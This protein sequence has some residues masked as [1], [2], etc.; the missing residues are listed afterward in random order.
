MTFLLT[1]SRKVLFT[2]PTTN[3][4]KGYIYFTKNFRLLEGSLNN[5]IFKYIFAFEDIQ[6]KEKGFFT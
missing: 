5:F 3:L 2:I 6:D 1:S 4:Q